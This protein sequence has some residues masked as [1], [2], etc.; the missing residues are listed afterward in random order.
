[1]TALQEA[2]T[3][4][5]APA[6]PILLEVSLSRLTPLFAKTA[7]ERKAAEKI[8]RQGKMDRLRVTL[9]GGTALR[10]HFETHLSML[11]TL[12]SLGNQPPPAVGQKTEE[13]ENR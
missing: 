13:Q 4:P 2:L 1:M 3:A 12:S 7:E 9:E 11:E 10:L 8:G 5:V 6:P